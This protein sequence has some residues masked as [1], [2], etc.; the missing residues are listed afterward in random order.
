MILSI[1]NINNIGKMRFGVDLNLKWKGLESINVSFSF[2]RII[3]NIFFFLFKKY[4]FQLDG[5]ILYRRERASYRVN[6]HSN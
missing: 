3:F 5:F 4:K 6:R 2:I 1:N